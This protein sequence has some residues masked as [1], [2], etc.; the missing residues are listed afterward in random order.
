MPTSAA[1]SLPVETR[2]VVPMVASLVGTAPPLT[3]PPLPTQSQRAI[4]TAGSWTV[5]ASAAFSAPP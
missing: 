2:V 5:V 1:S 4:A 3:L